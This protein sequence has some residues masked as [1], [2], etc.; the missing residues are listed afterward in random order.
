[1]GRALLESQAWVPLTDLAKD[2][3]LKFLVFKMGVIV[4]SLPTPEK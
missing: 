4:P 3:S 2:L 1:M